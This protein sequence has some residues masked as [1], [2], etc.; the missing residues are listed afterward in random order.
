[1]AKQSYLHTFFRSKPAR[2]DL[3][4][5]PSSCSVS[6]PHL[7]YYDDAIEKQHLLRLA[8]E[9]EVTL[10]LPYD[11]NIFCGRWRYDETGVEYT[12]APQTRVAMLLEAIRATT[13][14]GRF[15]YNAIYLTDGVGSQ[16]I[17]TYL[18]VLTNRLPKRQS[19]LRI[20]GFGDAV[21]L[22]TY[23]GK[24]GIC[25]PVL[26]SKGVKSL[27]SD[28]QHV[29]SGACALTALNVA[30]RAIQYLSGYIMPDILCFSERTF[31]AIKSNQLFFVVSELDTLTEFKTCQK[32]AFLYAHRVVFVLSRDARTEV[33]EAFLHSIP[34][35]V[36]VFCGAPVGHGACLNN[37][38]PM[39]LFASAILSSPAD[40][41]VLSWTDTAELKIAA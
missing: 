22:H 20:F 10:T 5:I 19:T 13:A 14:F 21:R 24:M 30:A 38:Q 31:K 12:H 9:K 26:Y 3:V 36:P 17:L 25:T 1:M 7:E 15:K 18:K 35:Q 27:L 29:Y 11:D 32:M 39:T 23:L 40:I 6:K 41:P 8:Q 2:A 34:S 37:G 28:L 16:E 4:V 33:K